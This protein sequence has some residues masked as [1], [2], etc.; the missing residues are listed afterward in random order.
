M[1]L[2]GLRRP[3]LFRGGLEAL[4]AGSSTVPSN[5]GE[6]SPPV[7]GGEFEK[8]DRPKFYRCFLSFCQS[9]SFGVALQSSTSAPMG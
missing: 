8:I 2:F 7:A 3:R 9:V 5:S 1:T 6:E 4:F